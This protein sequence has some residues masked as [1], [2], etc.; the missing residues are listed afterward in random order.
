M[1]FDWLRLGGSHARS[2]TRMVRLYFY[3]HIVMLSSSCDSNLS[4]TYTSSCYHHLVTRIWVGHTHRHAIIILWLEVESDIHI[5][6]LSS[7][8]DSKLSWTDTSPCYH[9][10]VTRSW[11]GQTHRHAIIIL[12]L[13]VELDRHIVILSSSCDSKF[14]VPKRFWNIENVWVRPF[15]STVHHF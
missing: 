7:S 14:M 10:L 5:V 3:M 2:S 4:R 12:W 9:H 8:C 1:A 13:E 6:M 11:V 15:V